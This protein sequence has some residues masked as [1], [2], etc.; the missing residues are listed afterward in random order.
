M[1]SV[2]TLRMLLVGGAVLA[3][4]AALALHQWA[5]GIVLLLAVIPHAWLSW[6][7]RRQR[8]G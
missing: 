2:N 7:L 6:H 4:I 5:A 1:E 8:R 3:G